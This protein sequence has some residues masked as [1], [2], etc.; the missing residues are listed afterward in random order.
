ME[1]RKATPVLKVM[2]APIPFKTRKEIKKVADGETAQKKDEK[3]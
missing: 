2:D 1:M 3:V